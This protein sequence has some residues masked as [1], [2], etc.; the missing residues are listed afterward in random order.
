MDRFRAKRPPTSRRM[1]I[2]LFVKRLRRNKALMPDDLL[3]LEQMLLES[4][5]GDDKATPRRRKTRTASGCSSAR[6]SASTGRR[7]WKRSA[8]FDGTALSANQIHS[9]QPHRRRTHLQ[10]R[11]VEPARLYEEPPYTDLTARGPGHC[12]ASNRWT[13]RQYFDAVKSE[14]APGSGRGIVW[15]LVDNLRESILTHD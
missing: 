4:G 11:A 3:A 14:R 9:C 7:Q 13:N 6:Y 12:S 1:R 10:R 8:F 2:T 15:V 5:A